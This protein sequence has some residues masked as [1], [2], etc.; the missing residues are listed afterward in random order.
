MNGR[1]ALPGM[2]A[3]SATKHAIEAVQRRAAVRGEAL[4]SRCRARRAWNGQDAARDLRRRLGATR[5]ADGD[6]ADYNARVAAS[7]LAAVDGPFARFACDPRDVARRHRAGR[8]TPTGPRTR[9]RIAPSAHILLT[10]RRLLPDR[11]FDAL[12]RRVV[13]A[14]PAPKP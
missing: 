13:P 5:R 8:R 7:A 1:F 9:Y 4:R 3:Y 6:W 10:A 11:A 2:A 14:P 12:L